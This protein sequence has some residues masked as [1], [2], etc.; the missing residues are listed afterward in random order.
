MD[1]KLTPVDVKTL[2]VECLEKAPLCDLR[3][4]FQ[5][6]FQQ[7]PPPKASPW[8]L[9]G[10]IAWA[11]Q[12]Q[13]R[14]EDISKLRSR[15]MKTA[16]NGASPEKIQFKVGTR[17]IRSWQGITH[18]VTVLDH[19]YRYEGEHFNSL[20]EIA[21]RITGTRWSGPRFFGVEKKGGMK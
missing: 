2:S 13:S 16:L 7:H 4:W 9:R 14:G 19:G 6:L 8:V 18:E 17:L 15:L 12:A 5:A 21:R 3:S 1:I 11:I 10:N 20:S